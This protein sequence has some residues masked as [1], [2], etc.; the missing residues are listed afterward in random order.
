MPG[1]QNSLSESRAILAS[2]GKVVVYCHIGTV[3]SADAGAHVAR[4]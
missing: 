1:V 4:G 3:S 2:V